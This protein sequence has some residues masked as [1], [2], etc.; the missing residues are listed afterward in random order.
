MHGLSET[1]SN[2]CL[3]VRCE[4]CLLYSHFIGADGKLVCAKEALFIRCYSTRLIG[5]SVVQRNFRVGD[6]SAASVAHNALKRCSNPRRLRASARRAKEQGKR[7]G[8]PHSN[9]THRRQTASQ[10]HSGSP[11]PIN[12]KTKKCASVEP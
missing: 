3:P 11:I 2:S 12:E 4:A 1:R 7:Y 5:Q 8:N 10:N 6:D 9:M